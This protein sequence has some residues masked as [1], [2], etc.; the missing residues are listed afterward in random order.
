M[1][2]QKKEQVFSAD[3]GSYRES[4]G[5]G[6]S[7]CGCGCN[8]PQSDQASNEEKEIQASEK[9][10]N[11]DLLVIDLDTCKRCV[12]TG[13]QL[14]AAVQLLKPVSDALG[15][16]LHHKEIVV[17]TEAEA[18]K[19]ALLSSP[20]I[21]LN[22]RDIAEDICES[23]CES[24]GDLTSNTTVNCREWYYRGQVFSCTP[25]PMLLEAIMDAMLKIDKMQPVAPTPLEELP[26]NL[27]RYF[28]DKKAGKIESS[29]CK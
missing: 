24:C 11:V 26:K 14:K 8:A 4:A 20:T 13:D 22:G 21:R 16:S 29:C 1:K 27:Q 15:I 25:L 10:L 7:V 6:R 28:N 18:K 2:E 19:Y 3:L 23:A 12:P 17:Q 9:V 5:S